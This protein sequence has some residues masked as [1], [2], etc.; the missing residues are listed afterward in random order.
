MKWACLCGKTRQQPASGSWRGWKAHIA[1]ECDA[2][3]VYCAVHEARFG[4]IRNF[5][6][7]HYRPKARFPE[8]E[9][10]ISNLYLACAICNVLKCDDWPNEPAQDHTVPAYPD[11]ACTDYNE[12]FEMNGEFTLSS[13]HLAG[14]YIIER[15]M[16]NRGQLVLERRLS[17]VVDRFNEV[18]H[19]IR[20][21]CGRMEQ[22]ELQVAVSVLAEVGP[23]V[24]KATT[25]MRPYGDGDTKRARVTRKGTRV[26]K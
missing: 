3:C 5:H 23:A 10:A 1:D 6:V 17:A 16:L 13:G 25:T 7:E 22:D 15:M 9:N 8:L 21:H 26:K 20:A 18:A 24:A 12:L 2:R 4:G 11:P 14:Q 19:W